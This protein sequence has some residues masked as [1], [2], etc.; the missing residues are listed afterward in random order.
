MLLNKY[1]VLMVQ[2]LKSYL[3]IYYA[4]GHNEIVNGHYHDYQL[5][6]KKGYKKPIV[7][8]GEY[9]YPTMNTKDIRC[10]WINLRIFKEYYSS[11]KKILKPHDMFYAQKMYIRLK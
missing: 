9:L 3:K 2:S 1:T 11:F 8:D 10:Q 7:I 4:D 6:N 5:K